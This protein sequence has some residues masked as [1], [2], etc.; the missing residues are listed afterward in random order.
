MRLRQSGFLKSFQETNLRDVR[1]RLRTKSNLENAPRDW[2]FRWYRQYSCYRD[3]RLGSEGVS[4]SVGCNQPRSSILLRNLQRSSWSVTKIHPTEASVGLQTI[5]NVRNRGAWFGKISV[6]RYTEKEPR[7][8]V[9]RQFCRNWY[10]ENVTQWSYYN[11]AK[12]DPQISNR[13]DDCSPDSSDPYTWSCVYSF[14]DC[15][16]RSDLHNQTGK[17]TSNQIVRGSCIPN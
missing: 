10:A 9:S 14:A 6:V 12:D 8:E 15:E 7:L 17:A 13:H 2:W 3:I 5:R 11:V 4:M 16:Y 1:W